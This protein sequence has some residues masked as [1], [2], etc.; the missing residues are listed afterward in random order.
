MTFLTNL[1]GIL[2]FANLI[3]QTGIFSQLKLGK[4]IKLNISNWRMSKVPK[5]SVQIEYITNIRSVLN[6]ANH[7]FLSEFTLIYMDAMR[8]YLESQCI[9]CHAK[10]NI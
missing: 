2:D 1:T 3:F 8:R 10:Q 9:L 4:K 7:R 6:S 5:I